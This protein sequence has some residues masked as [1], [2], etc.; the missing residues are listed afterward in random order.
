MQ[1]GTSGEEIAVCC[2][3]V[4]LQSSTVGCCTQGSGDIKRTLLKGTRL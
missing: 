4:P 2:H 1:E 3:L